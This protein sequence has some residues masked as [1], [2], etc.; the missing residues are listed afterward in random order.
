[1]RKSTP[2]LLLAVA[3]VFSLVVAYPYLGL[4]VHRSRIEVSGGLHYG[5]LVTHILTAAV[6][7]ILGLLQA[8]PKVR[9]RRRIHRT[10]G[11]CYLAAG[12]LPAGLTAIPVALWSGRLLTQIGLTTAAVLWLLTGALAYRAARRRDITA[13]RDWMTRNYALTLLAVTARL[14]VPLL[15][16]AQIPLGT[17][18]PGELGQKAA[19][20]IPVGQTLAWIVNLAIAETLIRRRHRR[21]APSGHPRT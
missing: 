21:S 4:D 6:A 18:T 19:S 3:V 11:R 20:M 9:A 1:M 13:H 2:W 10:V 7:L 16:L 15:L 12:V 5:V 14:L 8:V 17:V